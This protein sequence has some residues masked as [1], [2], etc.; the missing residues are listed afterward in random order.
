M[1]PLLRSLLLLSLLSATTSPAE[2]A[3]PSRCPASTFKSW[4]NGTYCAGL[5]MQPNAT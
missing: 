2:E 5:K 1:P 4:V 3:H